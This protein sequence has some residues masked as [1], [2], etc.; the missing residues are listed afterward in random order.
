ML[1]PLKVK[2]FSVSPLLNDAVTLL[3]NDVKELLSKLRHAE[4][5]DRYDDLYEVALVDVHPLHV[6][7]FDAHF[8]GLV[9]ELLVARCHLDLLFE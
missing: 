3:Q 5:A 1:L 6:Q 7:L 9:L 4:I 8:H 2:A